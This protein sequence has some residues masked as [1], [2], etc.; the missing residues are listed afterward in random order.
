MHA[1][2]INTHVSMSLDATK[3]NILAGSLLR[4][5]TGVF[6]QINFISLTAVAV[7]LRCAYSI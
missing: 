3:R 1:H 7:A 5:S 6:T 4:L 2:I